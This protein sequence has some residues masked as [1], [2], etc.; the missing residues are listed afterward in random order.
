[1]K[2][3]IKNG[4][5]RLKLYIW[6]QSLQVVKISK[7]TLKASTWIC[8][9]PSKSVIMESIYS[10]VTGH[11]QE[12]MFPQVSVPLP[13]QW[14]PAKDTSP[15]PS[16][17]KLTPSV[18]KKWKKPTSEKLQLKKTKALALSK[19]PKQPLSIGVRL[20]TPQSL[21]SQTED[22]Q[23]LVWDRYQRKMTIFVSLLL[24]HLPTWNHLTQLTESETVS[25]R[26]QKTNGKYMG[27]HQQHKQSAAS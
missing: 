24:T 12:E 2:V 19:Q 7:A 22:N 15:V 17:W 27:K 10:E 14:L 26:A 21:I 11:S 4:Q 3:A 8:K 20:P 9:I 16:T 18:L 6:E 1:M 5:S 25:Q 23:E 13:S